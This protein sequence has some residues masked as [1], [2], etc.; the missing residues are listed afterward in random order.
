VQA[1]TM[2]DGDS[3]RIS[4]LPG[5]ALGAVQRVQRA[6]SRGRADTR[7]EE[8]RR[9]QPVYGF[10]LDDPHVRQGPRGGLPDWL[11][12]HLNIYV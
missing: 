1:L 3:T 5:A 7:Q 4:G 8:E 9:E 11:G 2:A 6:A 10:L 12:R